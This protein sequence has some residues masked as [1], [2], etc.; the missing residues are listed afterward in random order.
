MNQRRNTS[1]IVDLSL[2][3]KGTNSY[4]AFMIYIEAPNES[5]ICKKIENLCLY[6]GGKYDQLREC[7]KLPLSKHNKFV[8]KVNQD[9]YL[10]DLICLKPLIMDEFEIEFFLQ[11]SSQVKT[12]F[13]NKNLL[14]KIEKNK[15]P[16]YKKNNTFL[17]SFE[18]YERLVETIIKTKFPNCKLKTFSHGVYKKFK[19][20]KETNDETTSLEERIHP[21]I[22]R[23]LKSFQKEGVRLAIEKNGRLM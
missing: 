19:F 16:F 9:R 3:P 4:R 2:Y 15:I 23:N 22:Y 5:L 21:S 13:I 17:L 10:M 8:D 7:F 6:F 12:N 18:S 14:S 20:N 1:I 11:N